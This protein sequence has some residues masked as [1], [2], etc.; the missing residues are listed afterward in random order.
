MRKES[1]AAGLNRT[2]QVQHLN[3]ILM[4]YHQEER[5]RADYH[6][7]QGNGSINNMKFAILKCYNWAGMLKYIPNSVN[8]SVT[9]SKEVFERIE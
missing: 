1:A 2:D 5:K 8:V 4:S 3:N 6:L 9:C 7:A